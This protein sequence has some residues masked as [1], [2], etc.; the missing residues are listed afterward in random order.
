MSGLLEVTSE[1][2]KIAVLS[3]CFLPNHQIA[4]GTYFTADSSSLLIRY[5]KS[6]TCVNFFNYEYQSALSDR[7]VNETTNA[8]IQIILNFQVAA[9]KA[10]ENR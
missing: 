3:V 8:G 4:L 5:I 1:S 10:K 6:S 7:H 2:G 9:L